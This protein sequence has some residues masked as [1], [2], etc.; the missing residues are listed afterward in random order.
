[1][2]RE[3][4]DCAQQL[5]KTLVGVPAST[6]TGR[7]LTAVDINVLSPVVKIIAIPVTQPVDLTDDTAV[8][9]VDKRLS[10]EVTLRE[11]SL[12]P[13]H[14]Q[15]LAALDHLT[16]MRS[17]RGQSG[18]SLEE[19]TRKRAEVAQHCHGQGSDEYTLAIHHL[20]VVL[21][22]AGNYVEANQV[23]TKIESN[24]QS[25]VVVMSRAQN[26]I[27]QHQVA[28]AVA[29]LEPEHARLLQ[30]E[31]TGKNFSSGRNDS[32][33]NMQLML[34]AA[35]LRLAGE[36]A[37][38]DGNIGLLSADTNPDVQRGIEMLRK[39]E[40]DI[41]SMAG[42]RS[43]QRV[44]AMVRIADSF[45]DLHRWDDAVAQYRKALPIAEEVFGSDGGHKTLKHITLNLS[46]AMGHAMKRFPVAQRK[47]MADDAL[48]LKI[49]TLRQMEEQLGPDN[50]QCIN[51]SFQL[52]SLLKRADRFQESV[53]EYQRSMPRM[54]RQWLRFFALL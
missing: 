52:A 6:V 23:L 43:T 16:V 30:D 25:T 11:K 9:A 54:V 44:D 42:D 17:A 47:T 18:S 22:A 1:M 13:Y 7:I 2:S 51:E 33:S 48:T 21:S 8:A 34:G 20:S 49:K 53:D 5:F 40:M 50:P 26:L 46:T 36:Q 24:G 29:I 31:G 35:L 27:A 10:D 28:E 15:V 3:C 41:Q 19:V 38:R 32:V 4:R 45:T 37:I 14:P 12:G 39:A